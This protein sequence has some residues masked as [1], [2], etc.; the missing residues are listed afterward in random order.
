MVF[1]MKGYSSEYQPPCTKKTY[2]NQDG[3]RGGKLSQCIKLSL[4]TSLI[5][6]IDDVFVGLVNKSKIMMNAK[7]CTFLQTYMTHLG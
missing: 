4:I 6:L 7:G 2:N 3:G 1:L 5:E